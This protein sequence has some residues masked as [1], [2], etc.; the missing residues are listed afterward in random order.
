MRL[1]QTT[2]TCVGAA[3]ISLVGCILLVVLPGTSKLA[4]F[5][6][7]WA[8][9]GVGALIQT[10]IS[11]NVTGYTKKVFY[12]AMGMIALVVGNFIGPLLM[13]SEQAPKYT[14]ALIGFAA[15]NL[16]II[17]LLLIS[18][19]M[20]KKENKRRLDDPSTTPTDIYADLTDK[21]NRNIIY[22]L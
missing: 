14:G 7:C 21:Q 20:M 12:N 6:L 22:K 10:I 1:K 2:L 8:N 13:T 19:N 15:C 16:V 18:R 11:N 9:T 5:Y 3:A 4:G 17:I